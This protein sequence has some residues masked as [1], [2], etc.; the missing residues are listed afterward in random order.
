VISRVLL[1]VDR[2]SHADE[3]VRVAAELARA[4]QAEVEVLHVHEAALTA[5]VF[6]SRSLE[7]EHIETAEEARAFVDRTV[8]TLEGRGVH[9]SGR[10]RPAR[11]PTAGEIVAAAREC[12]AGLLVMGAL[13]VSRWRELLVGGVAHAAVQLAPCPVVV[14]PRRSAP[15]DLRRLVLGVDGSAGAARAVELTSELACRLDARV[16]VVHASDGTL[17]E[18]EPDAVAAAAAAAIGDDRVAAV[19]VRAAGPAGVAAALRDEA[20]EFAAGI[21]VVGRRGRSPLQRLLLGGVSERLL[22]VSPCPLL[23]A[24]PIEQG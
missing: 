16:L 19:R 15:G 24:P 23:V 8:A 6:S 20:V 14:V 7:R 12:G 9:A 4:L 21:L 2:S 1:A 3:A 17:A 18:H 11:G 10:V 22:H 13:G 5:S